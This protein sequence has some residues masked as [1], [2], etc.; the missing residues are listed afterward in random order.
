MANKISIFRRDSPS[1]TVNVSGTAGT[2][3]ITG[4]K[5]FFTVKEVD[6]DTDANAKISK[7]VSSHS[8]PSIGQTVISM[9]TADTN[10]EPKIYVYDIQMKDTASKI[11]TLLKGEFEVKQDVTVREA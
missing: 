9:G 7:D 10:I 5:F 2:V 11:T 8:N 6:T 4:Y 3:D 1:I